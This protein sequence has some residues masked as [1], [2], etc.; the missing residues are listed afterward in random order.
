[1]VFSEK[2]HE[3]RLKISPLYNIT[4]KF[5]C[6]HGDCDAVVEIEDTYKFV[7]KLKENDAVCEMITLK[8][9]K[10]A[11]I[12]FDYLVSDK[13]AEEYMEITL[14]FINDTKWDKY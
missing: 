11:F 13:E 9:A 14:N 6:M 1:M 10:H 12:L 7:E 4:S 3:N 5:L 8:G 2:T